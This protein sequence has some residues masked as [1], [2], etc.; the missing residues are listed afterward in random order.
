MLTQPK[1]KYSFK[2]PPYG[3][4]K[5]ALAKI[6][7]LDGKAGLWMEM[8]TGKTKVAIDWAGISYYNFGLRRVLVV[9]PI[10]VLRVWKRQIA[11]HSPAPN[12]VLILEGASFVK[13]SQMKLLCREKPT[14]SIT[15]VLVNYESIW[16]GDLE[17]WIGRW[18]PDL[19][20]CDESHRI[21][22]PSAKQSRSAARIA[23][24]VNMRLALTGTPITK[25]PLDAFGQFRFIDPT[26]FGSN[27]FRFKNKYGIWGGYG[28][29]QIMGY[30][31]LP[32]L[33]RNIR[34]NTFRIKKEDALDLPEKVFLDVPVTL[35]AKAIQL[36]KQM[37]EEMI[38]EIEESHATA[39]IV[40]TKILRLSQITS[41]FIKD[42]EGRIRIFDNS[43]LKAC[44]DLLS[45]TL[46]EDQKTVIFVR[47]RTDIERLSEEIWKQFKL[48]PIIL[49]GSVPSTQR[50][51][52]IQK[53]HDDPEEKI[54]IAQ[55]Q[56]GSLGIDLTPAHVAIF[57]SLD[58]NFANYVQA[59][60][61]LHRIGQVNKVTYY[62]LVVPRT[63]DTLTLRILKE[64][65][66]IAHAIVHDPYI[67]RQEN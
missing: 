53:F 32:D 2:T 64:K 56:A 41:G 35:S 16:R 40:L 10:S 30:K 23:Q 31:N 22:T 14:E 36:Y 1:L 65:G 28:R 62:H 49:S 67:L 29:Y 58:Y 9:C 51:T 3:Y 33:I 11:Q 48:H 55:I 4:Q 12:R 13:T 60:D 7:K 15:W 18:N 38:I 8:G 46:A 66:D 19:V 5:R 39:A 61:R 63:I 27:W 44:M 25:S 54:F 47:F 20:I 21:K 50:D 45:D 52:L 24:R 6:A 57:Y 26:V 42:V 34:A 37:A 59:Q 17:A 43:K